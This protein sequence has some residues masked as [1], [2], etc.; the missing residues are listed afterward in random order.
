ME[1]ILEVCRGRRHDS[2]RTPVDSQARLVAPHRSDTRKPFERAVVGVGLQ[3]P[4]SCESCLS[5][6]IATARGGAELM[7]Q[8]DDGR[9]DAL[10]QVGVVGEEQLLGPLDVALQ[11]RDARIRRN[12]LRRDPGMACARATTMETGRRSNS[13]RCGRTLRFARPLIVVRPAPG[14]ACSG[15]RPGAGRG[16]SRARGTST[17]RPRRRPRD[18]RFRADGS[19]TSD[20]SAAT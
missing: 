16:S 5:Q 2:R 1:R 12:E 14:E 9:I 10:E 7:V 3:Q 19:A 15:T 13:R 6:E 11:E 20:Q 4:V 8:L 18:A 17:G